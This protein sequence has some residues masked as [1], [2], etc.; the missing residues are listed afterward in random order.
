MKRLLCINTGGVGNLHG[1]RMRRLTA[2]LAAEIVYHDVERHTSRLRAA[3]NLW[4]LI[5]HSGP[6]DL[7]YQEGTGITA[8][9]CLIRA[10]RQW[11]QRFIV[12]SGDP[13]SGFFE[14]T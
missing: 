4:Q 8:G 3:S 9:G 1:L 5:R 14:V 10:N 11:G 13:I 6:W 2:G 7:I 12:S